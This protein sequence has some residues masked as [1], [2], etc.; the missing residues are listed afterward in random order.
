LCISIAQGSTAN[1]N[2]ATEIWKSVDQFV[3]LAP[4][5]VLPGDRVPPNDHPVAIGPG[6]LAAALAKL[7][8]HEGKGETE[9][10]PLFGKDAARRLAFPL[11][12]ALSRA[13][14]DQDILFAIEMSQKATIFGSNPVSVA[15]R[16]FYQKQRLHVIIGELHVS[17]VSPEYKSYPIGYPKLDRRLHP[18]QTGGRS[19]EARYDPTTRFETG[20]DVN[21][22]E[23]NGTVRNDWLVLNVSA[24]ASPGEQAGTAPR[25]TPSVTSESAVPRR[26]GAGTRAS[27]AAP[28][29]EERLLRLKHLREQDLITAEDFDRKRNEILSEL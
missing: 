29:I 16:V 4:Q 9:P 11:S 24:L 8:V 12:T 26:D 14:A 27:S 2:K 3:V 23:R 10:V 15:G 18:H 28:S 6:D 22:F 17:T 20:D 21:L 1:S 7:Q 25:M 19:Q 5:D 13:T